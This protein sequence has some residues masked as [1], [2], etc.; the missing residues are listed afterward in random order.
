MA[1]DLRTLKPAQSTFRIARNPLDD[2]KFLQVR[3]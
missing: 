3:R 1:G 2:R